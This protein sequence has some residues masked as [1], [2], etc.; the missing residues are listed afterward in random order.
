MLNETVT[1]AEGLKQTVADSEIIC[2]NKPH[3]LSLDQGNSK[4]PKC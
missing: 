2:E 1:K 3:V 4:R